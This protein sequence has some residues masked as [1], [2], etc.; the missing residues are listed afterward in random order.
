MY[1]FEVYK[2]SEGKFHWELAEDNKTVL[3]ISPKRY[4]DVEECIKKIREI[5]DEGQFADI[6]Y[7]PIDFEKL[8]DRKV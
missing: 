4:D 3:A 6:N 2:S 1:K 7:S 8:S 5:M